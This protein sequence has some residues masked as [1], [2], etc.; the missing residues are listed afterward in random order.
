MTC[1]TKNP[2]IIY[3][4]LCVYEYILYSIRLLR[5]FPSRHV[6]L[7]SHFG[8]SS[9]CLSKVATFYQI[10]TFLLPHSLMPK[11]V[12]PVFVDVVFLAGKNCLYHLSSAHQNSEL[13]AIT[14][15]Q[16]TSVY[17]TGLP[18][19][20]KHTD[21]SFNQERKIG[22]NVLLCINSAD[23]IEKI[24]SLLY[25]L[26]MHDIKPILR[27]HPSI[28]IQTVNKIS[29]KFSQFILF[30]DQN[31]H[32]SQLLSRCR[33]VISG[34]SNIQFDAALYGLQCIVYNMTSKPIKDA[35][36]FIN[37]GLSSLAVSKTQVIEQV[38]SGALGKVI[39][40]ST[41]LSL[42]HLK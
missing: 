29:N 4:L 21:L 10:K 33:L 30:S 2:K 27:F 32:L 7:L 42:F 15:S 40:D 12:P 39:I 5:R 17:L 25:S 9:N 18:L 14:A 34:E 13:M 11:N 8:P 20:Y 28:D 1:D 3:N 6:V 24:A 31:S 19:S 23:K 38:L 22:P 37:N 26:S 41:N 36:G 35:Y 16:P